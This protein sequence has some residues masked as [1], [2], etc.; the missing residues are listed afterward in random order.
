VSRV[1]DA[2]FVVASVLFG[3]MWL[4]AAGAKAWA[5]LPAYEFVGYAVPLGIVAKLA[6]VG[7]VGA[8][9]LLGA[10]MILRATRGFGW[11]LAML[12]GTVGVLFWVRAA[13]GGEAPCGCY[14]NAFETRIDD[15]LV[16]DGVI[17]A[18]HA[19]LIVWQRVAQRPIA[20]P[21]SAAV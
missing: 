12:V 13:A 3:A 1:R 9:A 2:V 6:I 19:G 18:V 17:A 16:R 4:F 11:S 8:E 7:A 20:S 14:S 21:N 15:E 5:P 10:A